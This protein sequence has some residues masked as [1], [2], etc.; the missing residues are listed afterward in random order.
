MYVV[1][2]VI[3]VSVVFLFSVM[4]LCQFLSGWFKSFSNE[5]GQPDMQTVTKPDSWMTWL[6]NC[7]T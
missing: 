2:Q 7:L 5:A 1:N 6:N 3:R 4:S